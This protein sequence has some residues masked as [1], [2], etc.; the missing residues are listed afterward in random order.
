MANELTS[1]DRTA[2]AQ[3]VTNQPDGPG[4]RIGKRGE[5]ILFGKV[6]PG[7][8]KLFRERLAQFQAEAAYWESRVGTVHDF[9]TI[10]FDDD[11]RILFLIT[12]DGDFKAYV[13]DIISQAGPWFDFFFPDVWEGY[14][15]SHDHRTIELVLKGTQSADV[16]YVAHPDVTVRDIG[17]MK[18]LSQAVSDLLD[19]AS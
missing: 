12:F 15:G 19:A 6:C 11:T 4:K 1:N 2:E 17:K 18:K 5:I 7:G 13:T 8:G 14:A 16:F 10:L 3:T 9:R